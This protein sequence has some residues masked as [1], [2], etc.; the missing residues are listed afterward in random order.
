MSEPIFDEGDDRVNRRGG[1]AAG[2][3]PRKSTPGWV[4]AVI[5]L[6]GVPV[7]ACPFLMVLLLPAV[8]GAREAARR[9]QARNN[10]K[11]IGLAA[12]NFHDM[13]GHFPPLVLPG[14]EVSEEAGIGQSW[15]T[16]LLPIVDHAALY[17]SIDR[18]LAW[19][20]PANA[21]PFKTVVRMFQNPSDPGPPIDDDGY[22][23][24]HFASN[25][26]VISDRRRLSIREIRDGTSNMILAGSIKEGAKAW[27]D[28]TNHRDPANGVNGGPDE[29]G[30]YHQ[31]GDVLF[32][33]ADGS[34]RVVSK[35][36]DPETLRRLAN[37]DDG[38]P[39][40]DDAW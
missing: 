28:P 7:L 37:P 22:A 40:P 34:V 4:I 39:I 11:Q 12:H 2:A 24:A 14:E 19:N 32:L 10:L 15:M 20:D 6:A 36:I 21:T 27:G 18:K 26:Q 30:S 16:D 31:N 38:L 29:F 33:M 13:S 1:R 23:L 25:S 35:S 5:I 17:V 9:T 8:Q 3:A